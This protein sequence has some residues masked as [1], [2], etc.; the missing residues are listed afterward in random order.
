MYYL[1]IVDGNKTFEKWL[2][3]IFLTFK[4]Y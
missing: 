2:H 4:L 3:L 1:S